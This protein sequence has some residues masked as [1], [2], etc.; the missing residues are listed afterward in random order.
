MEKIKNI[1]QGDLLTFIAS[2][3]N[4]KV[5]LCTNTYI[6]KSPHNFTF[7][8]LDYNLAEKPTIEI[9]KEIS[10]FGVGNATK[11]NFYK[12]SDNELEKMWNFHPE[13]KPHLLGFYNFIIWKKDFIKFRDHFEF[14]GNLKIV[15]N[16]EK[17]GNGGLNA[18]S[19]DYLRDFFN[20]N[21]DKIMS[22][23]GQ[24]TFKLKSIIKD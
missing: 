21:F 9:I 2:D 23:R 12:H 17:N 22:E 8:A 20:E 3:G 16:I 10:F 19:W 6:E 15:N 5:I 24:L 4:Y 18:S 1:N 13:I 7:C 11:N 14:I